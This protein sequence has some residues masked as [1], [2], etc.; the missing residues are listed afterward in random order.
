MVVTGF[1]A[2]CTYEAYRDAPP[3]LVVVVIIDEYVIVYSQI[4]CPPERCVIHLCIK[5]NR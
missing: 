1:F 4:L 2:Q 5:V 3:D